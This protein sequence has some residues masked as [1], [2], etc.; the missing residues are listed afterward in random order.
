[1]P[2]THYTGLIAWQKA[3]DLVEEV[4]RATAAFPKE[5]LFGLTSQIR[6]AAVSVPSNIAEGQGRASTNEFRHHLSIALGS[7][8]ELVNGRA[9]K[10]TDWSE[11]GL[12]IVR[13]QNL[14]NPKAPFN[15]FN[16]ELRPRFLIDSGALLFAWSG[17]PGTSFGA[18]I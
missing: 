4:Y 6:R 5:E 11:E 17:T 8:C 3:V 12:P 9:F 13:I 18:H 15:R 2:G 7:L 14:N 1:M 16:G 10:P